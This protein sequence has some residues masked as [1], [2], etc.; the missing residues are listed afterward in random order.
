MSLDAVGW[1][2]PSLGSS[3]DLTSDL[4]FLGLQGAASAHR[5]QQ[6][7]TCQALH[8]FVLQSYQHAAAAALSSLQANLKPLCPGLASETSIQHQIPIN[9]TT[10]NNATWKRIFGKML[11]LATAKLHHK[12]IIS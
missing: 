3:H 10:N 1:L 12:I 9:A 8:L 5:T 4:S 6:R 2:V 7:V 11:L